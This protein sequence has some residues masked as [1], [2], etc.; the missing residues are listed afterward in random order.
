MT[1]LLIVVGV[2]LGAWV[3][4]LKKQIQE[5]C[6]QLEVIREGYSDSKVKPKMKQSDIVRLCDEINQLITYKNDLSVKYRKTD[7]ELKSMISSVS[8]DLRTPLTSI[9]GYLQMIEKNPDHPQRE[10]YL[11]ILRSRVDALER[12]I[13]DFYDLSIL[14]MEEI[15]LD[16]EVIDLNQWVTDEVLTYY[17]ELNQRFEQVELKLLQKPVYAPANVHAM[18]RIFGNLI[19]NALHYGKNYL[20]IT[21]MEEDDAVRLTIENEVADALPNLDK[22][23]ERSYRESRD[24]QEKNS[25]LGLSIVQK[26]VEKMNG[27]VTANRVD[28]S[29]VFHV[30]LPKK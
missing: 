8:H 18:E 20:Y 16:L 19:K 14:D 24:R 23:F 21:L 28:Q 4:F 5:I 3:Y 26:L 10:K 17:N 9:G 30:C 25:G 11:K 27:S 1:G 7:A 6:L 29:I 22:I 13:D 12:L 2:V 15:D